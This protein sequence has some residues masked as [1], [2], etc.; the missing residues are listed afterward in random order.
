MKRITLIVFALAAISFSACNSPQKTG[1][2]KADSGSVGNSG[3]TDG[4]AKSSFGGASGSTNM[5]PSG[6]DTST[7]GH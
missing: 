1:N 6:S 5:P 4:A 3:A 7:T 2:A